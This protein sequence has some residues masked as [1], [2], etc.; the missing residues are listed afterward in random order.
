MPDSFRRFEARDPFGRVWTIEFR[1]LQNAISIRHSDTIDVQFALTCGNQA[2][3]KTI[4][5][6][7]PALLELSARQGRPITDPWVAR[8]AAA[9]LQSMI[10]R[11]QDLDKELVTVPA[12]ELAET[13]G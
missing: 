4:A 6:A 8:L 3:T 9:H 13:R 10:G 1:W 5:I 7:H 12:G 2:S 11:W